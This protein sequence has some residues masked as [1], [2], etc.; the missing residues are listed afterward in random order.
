[1]KQIIKHAELENILKQQ[2]VI[3]E[4]S[5]KLLD[6]G[7]IIE[8]KLKENYEK[9]AELQEAGSKFIPDI[10]RELGFTDALS[11][12]EL[13]DKK[14]IKTVKLAE[15]GEVEIEITSPKQR[16]LEQLK[17]KKEKKEVKKEH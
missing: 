1:M 3:Q 13:L 8:K 5:I 7:E 15:S 11:D 12:E 2:K 6:K 14:E 10:E 4:D 16:L 9:V 17:R